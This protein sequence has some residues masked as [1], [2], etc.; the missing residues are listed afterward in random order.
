MTEAQ[1]IEKLKV[2]LA[3][4]KTALQR[5]QKLKVE[6]EAKFHSAM[7]AGQRSAIRADLVIQ[8]LNVNADTLINKAIE[9]VQLRKCDTKNAVKDL[10]RLRGIK[11]A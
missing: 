2:E 10:E 11:L 6:F 4:F 8:D 5:E 9:I 3:E 7:E 1:I